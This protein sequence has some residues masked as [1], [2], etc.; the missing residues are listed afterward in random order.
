M[1]VAPPALRGF[2]SG[3]FTPLNTIS[4]VWGAG[5]SEAFATETG[6]RGWKI[7]VGVQMIPAAIV[8]VVFWWTVESPRWLLS[9]G[10]KEEA[11]MALR[12]LRRKEDADSGVLESEVE[13]LIQA[14]E[15]D[16]TVRE[17]GYLDLF[18]GSMWRRSVVSGLGW[19]CSPIARCHV[20]FL[21]PSHGEPGGEN[22]RPR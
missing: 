11:L 3:L 5:M 4:S 19:Q 12:K 17:G 16:K 14:I 8:L 6:P 1:P 13:A 2:F 20:L 10:Q 15:Y 22:S 18:R 9:R 21:L 7:P